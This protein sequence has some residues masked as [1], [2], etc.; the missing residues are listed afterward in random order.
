MDK[1]K[2]LC[3]S[4]DGKEH[5]GTVK[6]STSDELML[7]LVQACQA[8]FDADVTL[9]CN[10]NIE[11]YIYGNDGT[12]T[13]LVETVAHVNEEDNTYQMRIFICE[14]WLY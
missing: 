1:T 13:V 6:A 14:T 8:H 2:Y 12:I 3:I 4:V 7:G 11:D 10:V 9:T 5:I